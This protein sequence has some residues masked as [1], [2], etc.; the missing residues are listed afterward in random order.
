VSDAELG[1]SAVLLRAAVAATSRNSKHVYLY[2][3]YT[4]IMQISADQQNYKVN[5]SG[6]V[7]NPHIPQSISDRCISAST[8]LKHMSS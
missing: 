2:H 4:C 1:Q 8:N 6:T 5:D 3:I 7:N